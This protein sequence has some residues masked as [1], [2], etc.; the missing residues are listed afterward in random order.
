MI[1]SRRGQRRR[2]G[3]TTA[4]APFPVV[5]WRPRPVPSPGAPQAPR[6]G[7][8]SCLQS[9]PPSLPLL[10]TV[11]ALDQHRDPHTARRVEASQ[12]Q[13]WRRITRRDCGRAGWASRPTAQSPLIHLVPLRQCRSATTTA[14]TDTDSP[15][16]RTHSQPHHTDYRTQL[17][18]IYAAA[19]PSQHRRTFASQKA[20]TVKSHAILS[21]NTARQRRLIGRKNNSTG[22]TKLQLL[23]LLSV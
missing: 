15:R 1:S 8:P 2:P 6:S 9:S 14:Q 17:H 16:E 11:Y 4:A 20:A 22:T 21:T 13:R 23:I 5:P 19:V 10:L 18:A 3:A 7:V 12:R